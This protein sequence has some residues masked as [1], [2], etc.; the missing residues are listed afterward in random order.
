MSET[1]FL[2]SDIR[3]KFRLRDINKQIECHNAFSLVFYFYIFVLQ[4]YVV[5]TS[6]VDCSVK[7][8]RAL[9]ILVL[10][11]LFLP[12]EYLSPVIFYSVMCPSRD[13]MQRV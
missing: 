13:G 6:T 4:F 1:P 11:F 12:S 8:L 5:P 2:V 10:C 7:K 9:C 3:I